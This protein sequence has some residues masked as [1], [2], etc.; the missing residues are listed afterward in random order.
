MGW[1]FEDVRYGLRCL[2]RS[3]GFS[4][5]AIL[6]LA[7]SIAAN[8]S[9][10]SVIEAILLRP[11]RYRNPRRLLLLANSEDWE[12]GGLLYR[13]SQVREPGV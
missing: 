13:D 7:V 5:I 2:A 9:I 8:T 11:L 1:V 6:T 4:G 12:D 10:F 3:P